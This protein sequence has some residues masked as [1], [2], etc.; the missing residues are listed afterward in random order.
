ML[1]GI[2]DHWGRKLQLEHGAVTS[3]RTGPNAIRLRADAHFVII[4]LT[5]QTTRHVALNSDR[6]MVGLAPAGSI[7]LVPMASELSA[8]WE[9][10][11]ENILAGLT[12]Q[13]LQTLAG[14]EFGSDGFEFHP[15]RLGSVDAK[16]LA[17]G[18]AIRDEL[19]CGEFA[20][21][22]CVDAWLTILG[23]HLLRRYSSL[24]GRTAAGHRG[25]LSPAVWRKVEDFIRA[26]L[27]GRITIEQLAETA[28]LSPSHFAR[29]FRAMTGQAPH[30]YVLAMRLEAARARLLQGGEPLEKVA[31]LSGFSSHSHMTAAMRRLWG[32]SPTMIR[33][34]G[35]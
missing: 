16:A 17:I 3:T 9:E 33:R 28:R 4:L 32:V 8:R 10:P 18:R 26:H 20:V 30:Q 7:E 1:Q 24:G 15:P 5:T 25:G 29:S 2:P 13:R 35:Y 34:Q 14:A 19:Q 6:A 11:K 23:T 22:E 27:A 12:A 31:R 21:P